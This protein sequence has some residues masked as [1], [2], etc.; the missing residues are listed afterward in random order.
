[1]ATSLYAG[2]A[3]WAYPSWKPGFYPQGLAA[4]AFL[5]FYASHL[6]A[7]EVNYTFHRLPPGKALHAWVEQTPPAFRFCPKAHRRITHFARLRVPSDFLDAFIRSLEPLQASGRLG[8]VLVQLPPDFQADLDRLR[9]FLAAWPKEL[10]LA[11]EF[12]HP[13]WFDSAVL[14]LLRDHGAALC[15]A[16]TAS[17]E[18]PDIPTAP[19][20]YYRFRKPDYADAEVQDIGR[21]LH[22]E[23]GE[24]FAFFKHEEGPEG[25]LHAERLLAAA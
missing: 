1:M 7:V 11:F 9:P 15:V 19:F 18:T 5:Q 16:Q 20:R 25:A 24:V 6:P 10:R 8:P 22:A 13:S 2:T 17:G 12:R 21:R 3:G 14:Q 4:R 23:P